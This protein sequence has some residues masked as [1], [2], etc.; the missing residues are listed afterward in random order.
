MIEI[1]AREHPPC[2]HCIAAV[3]LCEAQ[4]IE[5]TKHVL[6]ADFTREQLFEKFPDARTFPQITDDGT[7]VGGFEDLLSTLAAKQVK[8]MGFN[9]L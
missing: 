7:Y 9:D 4:N 5:Y 2:T 6:G 1:Y 8:E 3:N